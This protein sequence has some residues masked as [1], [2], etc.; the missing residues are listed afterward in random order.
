LNAAEQSGLVGRGHTVQPWPA[1]IGNLQ[2]VTWDFDSGR[3]DAASDP[4]RAGGAGVRLP[5]E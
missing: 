5:S 2:V 1:T 4:R 3:V